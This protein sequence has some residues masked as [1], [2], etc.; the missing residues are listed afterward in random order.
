MSFEK[1]MEL[2]M[3]AGNPLKV[4]IVKMRGH[5]MAVIPVDVLESLLSRAEGHS[6]SL[7]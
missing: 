3:T 6:I 4:H 2:P 1:T 7:Q 5:R